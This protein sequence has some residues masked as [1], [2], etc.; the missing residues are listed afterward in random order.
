MM[1]EE[2]KSNELEFMATGILLGGLFGFA[3][4]ILIGNLTLGI[5]LGVGFGVVMSDAIYRRFSQ[6]SSGR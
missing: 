4:F 5:G 3:L 2:R 6:V 1:I